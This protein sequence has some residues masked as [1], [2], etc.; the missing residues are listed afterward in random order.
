MRD[1]GFRR[2]EGGGMKE[3]SSPLLSSL[4]PH[5]FRRREGNGMRTLGFVAALALLAAPAP[6]R[7][8]ETYAIKIKRPDQG[9][10]TLVDKADRVTQEVTVSDLKGNPVKKTEGKD[11]QA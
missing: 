11:A 5:P 7:G 10:T 9:D 3:E 4:L 2:D 1:E 6:A 8:Q